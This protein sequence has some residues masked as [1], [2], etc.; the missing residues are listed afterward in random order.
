MEGAISFGL[1]NI[2]IKMF[3]ATENK[4]I[5]FRYLHRTCNTINLKSF[6]LTVM[7]K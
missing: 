2:P 6:A 5:R 4:D 1:V 3:T 7:L